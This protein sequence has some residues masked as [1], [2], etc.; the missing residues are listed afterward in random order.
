MKPD[1]D[2]LE[3]LAKA[4][5]P[6]P[7]VS[8]GNAVSAY[9]AETDR[10][11]VS[12]LADCAHAKNV[13]T[14]DPNGYHQGTRDA[15]FIAAARN[16]ILPLIADLRAKDRRFDAAVDLVESAAALL[17]VFAE[18]FNAQGDIASWSM[19]DVMARHLRDFLAPK[20][21]KDGN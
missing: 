14:G 20:E 3:R 7:W 4:A 17:E 11:A 10:R 9:N 21:T 12:L 15:A 18:S 8:E 1:L 5:T 6:A 19:A 16:Q 2:E 13:H